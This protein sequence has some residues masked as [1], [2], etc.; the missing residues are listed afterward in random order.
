[1]HVLLLFPP[2]ARKVPCQT[3]LANLSKKQ[4]FFKMGGKNQYVK[5]FALNFSLNWNSFKNTVN[6]YNLNWL[7]FLKRFPF[8]LKYQMH[9]LA[10]F[11]T[12]ILIHLKPIFNE[13]NLENSA[14]LWKK[15]WCCQVFKN[16]FSVFIILTCA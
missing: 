12:I 7:R 3:C 1:M 13:Y 11:V 6:I 14:A 10:R 9:N 15:F 16:H 5:K 4:V 8:I 2:K